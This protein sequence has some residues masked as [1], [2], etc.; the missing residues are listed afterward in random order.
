MF[1]ERKFPNTR[2]RRLRR[3]TNLID[4]VSETNLS[5][6]DLIQPIFIKENFDGTEP[7]DSMPNIFRHGIDNAIKE[8]IYNKLTI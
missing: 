2:L 5:S 3:N 6:N 8:T 4:L 7:I 1:I